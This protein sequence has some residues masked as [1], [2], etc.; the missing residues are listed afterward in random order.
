MQSTT[1]LHKSLSF[2]F[3]RENTDQRSTLAGTPC[4]GYPHL[5]R[6]GDARVAVDCCIRMPRTER[7]QSSY[8]AP[9]PLR[10]ALLGAVSWF[11]LLSCSAGT[12]TEPVDAATVIGPNGR[13]SAYIT[14]AISE[15]RLP[16]DLLTVTSARIEG[17]TVV[18]SV[19]HGGGCA[20]HTYQL[21]VS[22]RWM[23][24]YPVQVAAR[25]SH[26]A[27]GDP[28]D[29]LLGTTLRFSLGTVANAYRRAYA[30]RHDTIVIRLEGWDN[31]AGLRYSF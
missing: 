2:V 16:R 4:E 1:P 7:M 21:A 19:R 5:V 10:C 27:R 22:H 17:D 18:V 8:R 14:N 26:D 13:G 25:V 23:E 24:S 6:L 9:A 28:C 12:A 15:H 3:S 20:Q 31:A 11:L 29:A 30:T